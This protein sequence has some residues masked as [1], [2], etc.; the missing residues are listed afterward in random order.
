MRIHSTA[1]VSDKASLAADV[2][3][4]PYSIIG[5]NV[6]IGPGTKIAGHSVIQGNTT[7]GANCEVFSFAAVGNK[8][9][10]LKFKGEKSFLE[11]GDNNVIREFC[12]LN[13]G[14]GEGGKTVIGNNNL[15]M[16]YAHVAHD[17][18]VGNHC[19]IV[20]AAT[21]AGHVVVEDYVHISGFGAAHQ[22]VRVGKY[23]ILAGLS[24]AVQDVP[25]FSACDGHPARLYGLN[26]VGLKRY[27][28]SRESIKALGHAFKV[29]FNSG[30]PL[31]KAVIR[32]KE[33]K[34]HCAEVAYLLDFIDNSSRGVC[35]SCR[36]PKR[37]E[38]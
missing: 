16:A 37:N 1:I 26:M 35:R 38:E 32:L 23:S 5:D 17:C 25:P 29:L 34:D 18:C 27:N 22:F 11:I 33:E 9:Q 4:G 2:E 14:T 8:P 7:I 24:K 15:F 21:L 19:V 10:D 20:N 28:I 12:T 36:L 31:K 3:V 13:P 30:L 6:V